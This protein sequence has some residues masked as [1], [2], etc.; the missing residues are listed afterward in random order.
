[1]RDNWLKYFISSNEPLHFDLESAQVYDDLFKKVAEDKTLQT[2]QE[3]RKALYNELE[4]RFDSISDVFVKTVIGYS[5]T[6]GVYFINEGLS[7]RR[8]MHK[9]SGQRFREFADMATNSAIQLAKELVSRKKQYRLASSLVSV[10]ICSA[11]KKDINTVENKLSKLV[12]SIKFDESTLNRVESFEFLIPAIGYF[13]DKKDYRTDELLEKI[14]AMIDFSILQGDTASTERSKYNSMGFD[15]IFPSA[16]NLKI[17]W[18]QKKNNKQQIKE[19]AKRY[20]GVYEQLAEERFNLGGINLEASI[21]HLE[22]AVKVYQKYE[23]T[24]SEEMKQAKLRLDELKGEFSEMEHPNSIMRDKNLMDYLNAEEQTQLNE[25]IEQFKLMERNEQIEFLVRIVPFI[26]RQE[27]SENRK[28]SKQINQFFEVFPVIMTNEYEQII[29]ESNSETTKESLAL[30]ERIQIIGAVLWMHLLP[31]IFDEKIE[32]DF[33]EIIKKHPILS[34]RSY[35]INKAFELF[36]LG[37]IY[38]GLYLLL[39]QIEWWFREVAKQ[40]GEQTSNLQSFPVE[41]SKT[42]T[43]IFETEALKSY[44]GENRHWLFKKLMIEEPM[45]IRN[46]VAHGLEFNDNGY[47]AYFVLCIMK[48]LFEQ[49]RKITS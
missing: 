14:E 31:V 26:T 3:R 5:L 18:Y 43:P 49:I 10:A 19:V 17:K 46:K 4:L 42:L 34:K 36:F 27:I 37:D 25:Y 39:P 8:T 23:L 11:D 40:A 24:D 9:Y 28:K 12:S 48:L 21:M 16:F 15:C 45:N 6:S 41:R 33:S 35:Y 47:C 30:F 2:F 32:V 22:N 1:M 44:L 7:D 13:L 38:S 20:A 29:F